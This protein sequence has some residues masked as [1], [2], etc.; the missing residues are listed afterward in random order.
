MIT[1]AQLHRAA[2]RI[3]EEQGTPVM[4]ALADAAAEFLH[5]MDLTDEFGTPFNPDGPSL[6]YGIMVGYLAATATRAQ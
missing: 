2:D 4:D 6:G 5:T 1:V 3:T